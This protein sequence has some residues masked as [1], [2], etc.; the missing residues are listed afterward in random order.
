MNKRRGFFTI[1]VAVLLVATLLL[2]LIS[3]RVR[4][5]EA[6]I[7]FTFRR[8]APHAITKP[9]L[10]WKL[11]YP[12]QTVMKFDRRIHIYE[13]KF[14]E[15]L[16]RDQHNLIVAVAVGWSIEQPQ[17]FYERVGTVA[18]A[19]S[20]L[21]GLVGGAANAVIN[22]YDLENF[23]TTDKEKFRYKEIE[24]EIQKQVSDQA[25]RLYG[26]K[27][28]FVRITQLGLPEDVTQMVFERIRAERE[29]R[30]KALRAE[31]ESLAEQI[32]A[33]ADQKKSD[34]LSKAE[35]QARVIRGEADKEAAKHYAVFKSDPQL[36][37]FLRNLEAI[38]KLKKRTTYVLTTDSA[39]YKLLSPYLK[40]PG[41]EAQ[42]KPA[43]PPA[44]KAAN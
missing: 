29:S 4:L 44:P 23:V 39:P 36:A 37:E 20:K 35:A 42:K 6:A 26:L 18:E 7:V 16:T 10:Y 43:K 24:D 11:P 22:S 15:Y 32:R 5:N 2:F 34:I 30:A 19:E 28:A 40:L 27:V 8:A 1:L 17:I 41:D 31:G 13:G 3:F 12:I 33:A 21:A 38:R 25:L 14:Q 9:G